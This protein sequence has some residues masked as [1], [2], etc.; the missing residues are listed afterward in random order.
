[1]CD[2]CDSFQCNLIA[3]AMKLSLTFD[4]LHVISKVV[5]L[6]QL[7]GVFDIIRYEVNFRLPAHILRESKRFSFN[8]GNYSRTQQQRPHLGGD[9]LPFHRPP[10]KRIELLP[11]NNGQSG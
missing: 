1:M 6:Q 8:H 3:Y 5:L 4:K 2:Q 10:K 11:G 9:I 7:L